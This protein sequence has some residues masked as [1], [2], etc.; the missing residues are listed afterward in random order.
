MFHVS[1]FNELAMRYDW[2][3]TSPADSLL[4]H[5]ENWR[6]ES[7]GEERVMDATMTLAR[8]PLTRRNMRNVLIRYPFMTVKVIGAIYWQALKLWF[9]K[10]PFVGH[11][12]NRPQQQ[13]IEAKSKES[14]R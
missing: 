11:P 6:R 7:A 14:F 3:S 5:I 4:I 1:P 8:E 13:L 12:N 9:K 2:V 10:V